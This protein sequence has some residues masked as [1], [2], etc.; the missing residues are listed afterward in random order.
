MATQ[1]PHDH[2]SLLAFQA[3]AHSLAL[4][5]E[6][7]MGDEKFPYHRRELYHGLMSR[8]MH[9]SCM[10]HTKEAPKDAQPARDHDELEF[11]RRHGYFPDMPMPS[12]VQW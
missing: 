9:L 3:A 12:R 8:A 5:A 7:L 10:I 6:V 4:A 1:R 2:P 11:C